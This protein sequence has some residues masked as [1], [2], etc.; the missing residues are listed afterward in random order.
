MINTG[1]NLNKT[2]NK[3]PKKKSKFKFP[4]VYVVL[5]LL[6]ILCAVLTY[7][8]P[9]GEYERI[10]KDGI[11]LV[12]P[13]S[14]THVEQSP[15][16]LGG[17]LMS[18]P[19]GMI[20]ASDI[21]FLILFLGG[22]FRVMEHTGAINAGVMTLVNKLEHKKSVLIVILGFMFS[23]LCT[24]GFSSNATVAFIP[25]G[26]LI[27]KSLKLDAIAAV[28]IV[29]T[30][31]MAGFN[32]AFLN[33]KTLGIAQTIAE[34][35]MFSG[36]SYRIVL[37]VIFTAVTLGYILWYCR[38]ISEDPSKSLMGEHK[39]GPDAEEI[40]IDKN[41]KFTKQHA[42][43]IL[44]FVAGLGY[45]VYGSLKLGF[46]MNQMTAIFVVIAVFVGIIAKM[47]STEVVTSFMDGVKSLVYAALVTGV[48][49]S[50][51]IILE[52]GKILDTIIN[53]MAMQLEPLSPIA[54]SIGMLIA[55]GIFNFFVPSG[56]GQALITM[57]IWTP[58]ADMLEI[59]RQIAVQAFQFGDGFTN[60]L[61]PT[62]GI[63]M[64]ALT[65]AGVPYDKW[66]KFIWR[67]MVIWFGLGAVA[68]VVANLINWG[69]F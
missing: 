16:G 32:V 3:E 20:Q 26:L 55:N 8:V 27:A 63:L 1:K 49:R 13:E 34:L 38:R 59:N 12:N 17:I 23:L 35:P 37:F 69:P 14:Y 42:L 44:V 33:P 15:V 51:V 66:L 18:I 5:L 7:I 57:P 28:A 36:I 4:D 60:S 68:L 43:V 62:S 6:L 47:S 39:F 52:D 41:L 54:G 53:V 50:I 24:T 56:S 40:E 61:F 10:E 30:T 25:I 48:A 64:A 58:L 9:A 22:A 65:M 46:G 21:I 29:F 11:T 45:Y 67:L 31:S 2:L 19:E